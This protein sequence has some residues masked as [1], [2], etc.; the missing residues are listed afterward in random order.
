[1]EFLSNATIYTLAFLILLTVVVFV[2]EL[3]HF[4]LARLC[5][6]KVE[7]FSIGFGPELFGRTDRKGTR[8][9]FSAIPLGGY[10]KMFGQTEKLESGEGQEREMTAEERAVSFHHK[11]LIRRALVVAAG[12]AAN[13]VLAIAVFTVL[14]ATYGQPYSSTIVGKVE[15]GSAAAEAGILSGDKI[16]SLNGREIRRFE[17]IVTTIQIGLGEPVLVVVERNGERLEIQT[18]PRI[19]ET[20]DNFGGVHRIGRL[21]IGST[22]QG[23]IVQHSLWSA[24]IVAV[25]ET[26]AT[27]VR[28]LKTVWQMIAGVRS[29]DEVGGVLRIAKVAGDAAQESGAFFVNLIAMLSINLGLLNLFPIPMLDGGHLTF[30]A[31]EGLRGRPLGPNAQEWGLRIGFALIIGLMIFATWND[32]QYFEFIEKLKNLVS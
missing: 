17:D 32:I 20:T 4:W 3:G 28:I 18:E 2:H 11:S 30:Y 15:E 26:Y 24:F 9:K 16:V 13:F 29:S 1:M 22:G 23:D 25:D 14:F 5:G 8:W 19:I 21:G 12:P 6:V 7:V 10:V 27:S 31:V